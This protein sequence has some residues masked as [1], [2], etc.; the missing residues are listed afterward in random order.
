[1]GGG[2]TSPETGTGAR[3]EHRRT[4]V[5]VALFATCGLLVAVL[6]VGLVLGFLR[7]AG[8]LPAVEAPPPR[9]ADALVVLTGGADR[10]SDA[11]DLLASGLADRLL[12]TGVNPTT[13]PESLA[14]RLPRL[15][16]LVECCVTLGYQAL[17]TAGNAAETAAWVRANHVRSLIVVTS[18]Y[19]M[20]RAL[21]EIGGK[22][23]GVELL[24]YPVVSEHA[25]G[26]PWWTSPHRLRLIASEY[27]KY[28][29]VLARQALIPPVPV[30]DGSVVARADPATR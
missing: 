23:K 10:I 13:S 26:R 22:L 18:N 9:H 3:P 29:V 12:I 4:R 16:N 25:R 7:F 24:A 2:V 6:G 17:D 20:P 28:V 8:N 30:E 19:H 21:A 11:T 5:R 27:V 15:R 1:M 14:R